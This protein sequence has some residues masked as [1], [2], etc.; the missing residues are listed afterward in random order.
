M[1]L[2]TFCGGKLTRLVRSGIQE[3][4][5]NISDDETSAT[6]KRTLTLKITFR[7]EMDRKNIKVQ[8]ETKINKA[9][10]RTVET[11]MFVGKD[12]IGNPVFYS[13]KEQIAGQLSV[14][15][16]EGG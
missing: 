12:I 2:E 4:L 11:N 6:A 16:V 5:D 13:T 15:N 7:P 8:I 3:I 9:P 14:E 1:N 10:V